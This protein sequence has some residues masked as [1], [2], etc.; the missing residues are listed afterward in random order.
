MPGSS[1]EQ[2]WGRGAPQPSQRPAQPIN[3][4]QGQGPSFPHNQALYLPGL[5]SHFCPQPHLQLRTSTTLSTVRGAAGYLQPHFP[6]LS[7]LLSSPS[8]GQP[9]GLVL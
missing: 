3:P 2:A 9:L 7:S 6:C 8:R 5:S 4:L 1:Q